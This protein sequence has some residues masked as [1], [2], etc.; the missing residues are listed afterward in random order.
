MLVLIKSVKKLLL[1]K[2]T[3]LLKKKTSRKITKMSLKSNYKKRQSM[4]SLP[5][6]YLK[7]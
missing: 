1:S 5:L 4:D 3:T 6:K 7:K 2:L